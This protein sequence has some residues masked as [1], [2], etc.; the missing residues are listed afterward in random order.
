MHSSNKLAGIILCF[1][2]VNFTMVLPVWGHLDP[3]GPPG[4]H[5][6]VYLNKIF[7]LQDMDDGIDGNA[8]I[9]IF[10][11]VFHLGHHS[12]LDYYSIDGFNWDDGQSRDI[13]ELIYDPNILSDEPNDCTEFNGVMVLFL[14]VE[15]DSAPWA[16]II[17]TVLGAIA[18]FLAG[19]PLGAAGGGLEGGFAWGSAGSI[20]GAAGAAGWIATL[21]DQGI[22]VLGMYGPIVHDSAGQFSGKAYGPSGGFIIDY[23]IYTSSTWVS[24][25]DAEGHSCSDVQVSLTTPSLE[26]GLLKGQEF[27]EELREAVALANE[28]E[29]EEGVTLATSEEDL[30]AMRTKL[31]SSILIQYLDP[32]STSMATSVASIDYE[33]GSEALDYIREAR[34]LLVQASTEGDV[35]DVFEESPLV[36]AINLYEDAWEESYKAL[37]KYQDYLAN[38][39]TNNQELENQI[40]DITDDLT[41]AQQKIIT[42]PILGPINYTM[43]IVIIVVCLAM[44]YYLARVKR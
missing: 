4:L 18:G 15:D 35:D 16:S 27:F 21:A 36:K 7:L 33:L 6:E 22:D 23:E 8:E 29:I 34:V 41:E 5:V 31:L 38:L 17:G 24:P 13:D 40:I 43:I 12:V 30:V 3:P 19:G 11:Y 25:T 10:H 1:L 39:E 26:Q 14:V 9:K 37:Y 20:V 2:L 28:V 42:I 32:W 44:G